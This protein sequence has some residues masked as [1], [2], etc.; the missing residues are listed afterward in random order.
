MD[1]L[2]AIGEIVQPA[3]RGR[4]RPVLQKEQPPDVF[5]PSVPVQTPNPSRSRLDSLTA[6]LA[7]VSRAAMALGP[8]YLPLVRVPFERPDQG[9]IHHLHRHYPDQTQEALHN[10]ASLV[11]EPV[12]QSFGLSPAAVI[13]FCNTL[14]DSILAPRRLG[15]RKFIPELLQSLGNG[16]PA[17]FVYL[18]KER[19]AD[20]RRLTTAFNESPDPAADETFKDT[21]L[22]GVWKALVGKTAQGKM[23]MFVDLDGDLAETTPSEAIASS[24]ID[25]LVTRHNSRGND[26]TLPDQ[27]YMQIRGRMAS[28]TVRLRPWMM[29]E[30]PDVEAVVETMVDALD[31]RRTPELGPLKGLAPADFA[32]A[33]VALDMD[34]HTG[35]RSSWIELL[36]RLPREERESLLEPLATTWARLNLAPEAGVP[37]NAPLLFHPTP[38]GVE[39]RPYNRA[40]ALTEVVDRT[41]DG[42]GLEERQQFLALLESKAGPVPFL[43]A[44]PARYAEVQHELSDPGLREALGGRE[45]GVSEFWVNRPGPITPLRPPADPPP[46]L[47]QGE[48]EMKIS[49]V[50]EGGGARGFGYAGML[51]QLHQA[52]E[53]SQQGRFVIDEYVGASAGAIGAGLLASG[54]DPAA[55][56]EA[57]K[58]LDYRKFFADY[59]WQQGGVD[60]KARGISRSGLFS[61]QATYNAL[62]DVF[63]E[64]LGVT[65]RPILFRDLPRNLKVVTDVLNHD[66]PEGHPLREQIGPDG[67]LTFSSEKTP[68]VDVIAAIIASSAVPV[69]FNPPNLQVGEHRLQSVDGGV[70]N[71]FPV[72]EA[73][74]GD[75][76]GMVVLPVY[77]PGLATLNPDPTDELIESVNAV[78]AEQF[79]SYGSELVGSLNRARQAQ[80]YDRFV[81]GLNLA[82]A[83]QQ[84][85]PL[86]QGETRAETERL[87]ALATF[88]RL[89]PDQGAGVMAKIF[90][91]SGP[92]DDLACRLVQSFF[93]THHGMPTSEIQS[94]EE[95][96]GRVAHSVLEARRHQPDKLFER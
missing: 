65:G 45:V 82:D 96:V 60:P 12:E 31:R 68:D 79:Q 71:N 10:L 41:L 1:Q 90:Q 91:K 52:M 27:F 89:T 5:T 6:G 56:G 57:L 40:E 39:E 16:K 28:A 74:R 48:G 4:L 21:E 38:D 47:G 81:I 19:A 69:V 26:P 66:L 43:K 50:L 88:D 29:Q 87:H 94:Y 44:A 70:I 59:V 17:A 46:A 85:R 33:V 11:S 86:L 76:T 84:A 32:D 3:L 63:S 14:S 15:R 35:I 9:V 22:E 42:L 64:Q 51:G 53:A 36:S 58:K 54:M 34:P 2:R 72:A 62:Y 95:T 80:G 77:H 92:G 93:G 8:L 20:A 75:K 61:Q 37:A 13:D 73:A 78:N 30:R 49:L 25:S 24:V 18:G 55:M 23:P 67:Q 7:Q 83:E